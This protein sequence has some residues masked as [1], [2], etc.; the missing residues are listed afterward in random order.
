MA[1]RDR[2]G[3]GGPSWVVLSSRPASECGAKA[4]V[5]SS[6]QA[7]DDVEGAAV[8]RPRNPA[9]SSCW[10]AWS[11]I[12]AAGARWDGSRGWNAAPRW[13]YGK[14]ASRGLPRVCRRP[15][16]PSGRGTAGPDRRARSGPRGPGSRCRRHTGIARAAG[17]PGR[18]PG[19]EDHPGL[20]ADPRRSTNRRVRPRDGYNRRQP[21]PAPARTRPPAGILPRPSNGERPGGTADP[22]EGKDPGEWK[23]G[24]PSDGSLAI[25]GRS[26]SGRSSTAA[27]RS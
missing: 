23:R 26:P 13:A 19:Q 22:W 8:D 15:G 16:Y 18:R 6:R 25:A 21:P 27:G 10:R 24:Q 11:T 14:D 7:R 2:A 17:L 20:T 4:D 1:S 12:S 3:A 9:T 5:A